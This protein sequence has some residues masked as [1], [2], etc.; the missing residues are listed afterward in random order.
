MSV[1]FFGYHGVLKKKK[2]G[3]YHPHF[4]YN[5]WES[6]Q[7]WE[8]NINFYTTKDANTKPNTLA[9]NIGAWLQSYALCRQ[10]HLHAPTPNH[11]YPPHPQ[12]PFHIWIALPVLLRSGGI[13]STLK[14]NINRWTR[15]WTR[16]L[17]RGKE[18]AVSCFPPP[19]FASPVDQFTVHS[20]DWRCALI[21]C[22]FTDFLQLSL[23]YSF[24]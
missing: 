9:S 1:R 14:Q 5:S 17:P 2:V 7:L 19:L 23:W 4:S 10:A 21:G 15:L 8:N 12:K 13:G 24:N 3:L 18:G 20:S 6:F 16:E 11:P 22:L